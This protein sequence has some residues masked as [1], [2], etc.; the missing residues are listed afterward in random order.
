MSDAPD[1]AA[2][3]PE[4]PEPKRRFRFGCVGFCVC[5]FILLVLAWAGVELWMGYVLNSEITALRAA[6]EPVTWAEVVASIEPIPDAEN[7]ALVLQRHLTSLPRWRRSPAGEVVVMRP[8]AALGVRRSDEMVKLMRVC[9]TDDSATLK[10]LHDAAKCSSGRWPVD[11]ARVPSFNEGSH[12]WQ[13]IMPPVRLLNFESELRLAEGDGHGAAVAIRAI[14]R[15]GASLDASPYLDDMFVRLRCAGVVVAASERALA[16]RGLPA[17]DLT[18]LRGEFA[19]EAQQLSLRTVARAERA[20]LL[21]RTTDGRD[22]F[23]EKYGGTGWNDLRVTQLLVPGV[24]E[25]DALFGL[26]HMTAWVKLV[27]LDPREFKAGIRPL[28]SAIYDPRGASGFAL[29]H[30]VSVAEFP[31]V[32]E[33]S[34]RFMVDKQRMHVARAALAVEQ[35]R[36]EHDRWPVKLAELV[37]DYLDAVP[38]DWFA[39]AGVTISYARTAVGARLWSQHAD[40]DIGLTED[41]WEPL[42]NLAED[43]LRF[44]DK[45]GRCPRS[46]AELVPEY[47]ASIPI[48]PRTGQPF[49]YVTNPAAGPDLF[50]L[51]GVTNGVSEEEFWNQPV[52][53]SDW[54][55]RS[56][57]G[58]NPFAFR[59]LNPE[60]RGATQAGFGDEV[61]VSKSGYKLHR[62]GY[63]AE[64]LKELGFS[65]E[66]VDDYESQFKQFEEYDR[67]E[68]AEKARQDS[69]LPDVPPDTPVETT[70]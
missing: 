36:M 48:D 34:C 63:T 31:P 39:P 8:D 32:I 55:Q 54:V 67:E 11:A 29:F 53:E 28:C 59:L 60:L 16:Q 33:T 13:I 5:T 15:M 50:I 17:A 69:G 2:D 51:G 49:T 30:A 57:A 61:D 10:V 1:T 35:F 22:A 70:P 4:T 44:S 20:I 23:N 37:P 40:N 14:R 64:R 7:A 47:C 52:T 6:G 27:D 12:Y 56:Y 26:E 43:V 3:A 19:T 18:M 58:E 25:K 66:Q 68:A 46:L 62:L 9:V 45:V 24:A 38:Q 41:E 21:G 42:E 65:D